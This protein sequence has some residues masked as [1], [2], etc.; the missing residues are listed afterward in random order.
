MVFGACMR[1]VTSLLFIIIILSS[2]NLCLITANNKQEAFFSLIILLDNVNDPPFSY[3]DYGLFIAENLSALN[4]QVNV[5]VDTGWPV[6]GYPILEPEWDMTFYSLKNVQTTDMRDYYTVEGRNNIY[7]LTYNLPY[8]NQSEEMQLD[9]LTN[10]DIDAYHDQENWE[11]MFMDEILPILPMYS[12]RKYSINWINFGSFDDRWGIADNLP[13]MFFNGWHE[14]QTSYTELNLINKGNWNDLNPLHDLS[15][16]NRFSSEFLFEKILP[17]SPDG[18]PIKTGLIYDWEFFNHTH[19]KFTLKDNI[20]WNPSFDIQSRNEVSPPLNYTDESMLM[21][22]LK[23]SYSNGSNQKV[24]AKDAVF[25]LLAYSNSHVSDIHDR[26]FW[27]SNCYVD[28]VDPLSFH[29]IIDSDNLTSEHDYYSP[30]LRLLNVNLLPEFFLNSTS[31]AVSYTNGGQE[32]SGLYSQ[33]TQTEQWLNFSKSAFGCGK[34]LINYRVNDDVTAFQKTQNTPV[35]GIIDGVLRN[36]VI[37]NVYVYVDNDYEEQFARFS[38]GEIDYV[39]LSYAPEIVRQI[40]FDHPSSWYYEVNTGIMNDHCFLAFNLN[41]P[42]IGGDSNYL[43]INETGYENYTRACAVRKAICYAIDRQMINEYIHSGEYIIN[44]K[45]LPVFSWPYYFYEPPIQY[46]TNLELAWQWME[47][48]GYQKENIMYWPWII[49]GIVFVT[50][51]V[52]GLI[53]Y[54][55]RKKLKEFYL[56]HFPNKKEIY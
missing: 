53:I 5:I 43:W 34:Y 44:H 11:S 1:K 54:W 3:P 30:F 21:V 28:D 8:Q 47:A 38:S 45:P 42:A 40:D 46:E 14:G 49:S 31:Q 10:P 17:F 19:Y 36:P 24:S 29:V 18:V 41:Q 16:E 55:R 26:Y 9:L 51:I 2:S 12:P 23:G 27:L 48:A 25:S 33:I 4:I 20:Y 37:E 7:N 39:D 15:E 35:L 52:I 56:K 50:F 6:I 13:Y 32:Y 22:G